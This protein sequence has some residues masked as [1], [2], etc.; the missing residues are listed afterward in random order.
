[1]NAADE[2][3]QKVDPKRETLNRWKSYH[4]AGT[5]V[6]INKPGLRDAGGLRAFEYESA[7][8]R[9]LRL[10]QQ[11][12]RGNF[13][14]AHLQALHEFLFQDTYEWAGQLRDVGIAK[15]HSNFTEPAHIKCEADRIHKGLAAANFYE[16]SDKRKFVGQLAKHY[17]ELNRLH[18][19][20][21]GNGRATREYLSQLAER[22]GF[23]LDQRRIDVDKAAWN[24]ASA[25]AVAGDASGIEKIFSEAIRPCM[26]VA[27]EI[28]PR[29]RALAKHPDLLPAYTQLDGKAAGIAQRYAGNE[30]AQAHFLAHAKAEIIR[31]LDSGAT[32]AAIPTSAPSIAPA[33]TVPAPRDS[34][35]QQ[36]E[37]FAL[38]RYKTPEERESFLAQLE[39][40]YKVRMQEAPRRGQ[41]L[42]I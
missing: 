35:R 38:K 30:K 22:N 2:Q 11:P 33:P 3:Q 18:P 14:L 5:D 37:A 31:T 20:R 19:F 23:A 29:D 10:R 12:I 39:S 27:F 8:L 26:A 7:Y 9:T 4:Y 13:D 41:R 17:A 6:L 42:K 21:E 15:A 16:G 28:F 40:R 25:K 36:A 1:M 34:F 32:I 24:A